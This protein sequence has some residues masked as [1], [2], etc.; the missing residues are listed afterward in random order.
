MDPIIQDIAFIR[1]E[2]T[3]PREFPKTREEKPA[4]ALE[5]IYTVVNL[6]KHI[7]EQNKPHSA[8]LT[9]KPPNPIPSHK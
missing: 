7:S 8:H 3:Y 9:T 6:Y 5:S 4:I 1:I 2:Q